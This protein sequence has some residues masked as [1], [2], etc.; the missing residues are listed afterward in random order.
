MVSR[1][2]KSDG[3]GG[4]RLRGVYRVKRTQRSPGV[5]GRGFFWQRLSAENSDCFSIRSSHG[6][7]FRRSE[8]QGNSGAKVQGLPSAFQ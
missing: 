4:G 8:T 6:I 2:R 5:Q 7:Y 1:F 3:E